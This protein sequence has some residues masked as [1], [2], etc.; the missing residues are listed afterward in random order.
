[1]ITGAFWVYL[2]VYEWMLEEVIILADKKRGR[3][4]SL[5]CKWRAVIIFLDGIH[6][7]R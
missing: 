4:D 2:G 7:T 5:G 3:V 6:N 1:M